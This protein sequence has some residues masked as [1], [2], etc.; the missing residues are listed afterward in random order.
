MEIL[1]IY[2]H[3]LFLVVVM[4]F[5]LRHYNIYLIAYSAFIN[6]GCFPSFYMNMCNCFVIMPLWSAIRLFINSI[7]VI[8]SLGCYSF[9]IKVDAIP[10]RINL[11]YTLRSL[12]KGE[13]RGFCYELCGSGHSAMQ[14][15]LLII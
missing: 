12:I 13:Y 4:F 8:H 15:S 9:G 5:I 3:W 1:F 14:L 11:A 7:D 2:F 10:G 6:V